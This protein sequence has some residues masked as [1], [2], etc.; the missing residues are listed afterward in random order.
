MVP[1]STR[2]AQLATRLAELK[3]RLDRI[4]SELAGHQ[5]RDW[6]D[7][8]TERESDEV[9]ESMGLGGQHEIR[10]IEAALGRIESGDYGFCV[11][12]GEQIGDE[13]L[14]VLPFAPLCHNCAASVERAT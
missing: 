4:D 5:T 2:K 12:C 1:L 8:A 13:R 10:M 9:L 11:R 14:D 3:G 6:E 7:L